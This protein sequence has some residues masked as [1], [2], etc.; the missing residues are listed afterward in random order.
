MIKKICE[1]YV[2]EISFSRCH[3]FEVLTVTV[4]KLISRIKDELFQSADCQTNLFFKTEYHLY[5]FVSHT[6]PYPQ[7]KIMLHPVNNVK[8]IIIVMK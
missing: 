6:I 7:P 3:Q 4:G 8:V 5:S 1:I 2:Y